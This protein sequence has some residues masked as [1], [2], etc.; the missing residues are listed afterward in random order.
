MKPIESYRFKNYSLWYETRDENKWWITSYYI[1]KDNKEI[2]RHYPCGYLPIEVLIEW[3]ART[4]LKSKGEYNQKNGSYVYCKNG[5]DYVTALIK[6]GGSS[7]T[8]FIP[9]SEHEALNEKFG[10]WN[11]MFDPSN[12]TGFTYLVDPSHVI[13]NRPN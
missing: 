11:W 9:L 7:I 5:V 13:D 1:T 2:Y 10:G 8:T 3:E 6:N 4:G 12:E